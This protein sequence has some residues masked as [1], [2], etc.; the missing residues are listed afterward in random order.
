[1]EDKKC[2]GSHAWLG[3]IILLIIGVLWLLSDL[4][5]FYMDISWW[6]IVF[7]VFAVIKLIHGKK[8]ACSC[9]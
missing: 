9:K 6:P 8:C 1:M 3:P 7:I 4:G 5:V 2:C